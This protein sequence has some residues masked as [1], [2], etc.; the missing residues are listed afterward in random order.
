LFFEREQIGYLSD[1]PIIHMPRGPGIGD[2]EML[3]DELVKA[4]RIEVVK[5][6]EGPYE[7]STYRSM[8]TEPEDLPK[9]AIEAIREAVEYVENKSVSDLTEITHEFSNSWNN[10][11]ENDELNIY[12]DLVSP[13]EYVSQRAKM[14]ELA[15]VL[16]P[17]NSTPQPT[18]N[19]APA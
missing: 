17:P 5:V 6:P 7:R 19:T 16:R 14:D 18:Q 1:W 12:L 4:K 10:S 11:K 8:T 3:L 13:A 2:V 15:K 9:G